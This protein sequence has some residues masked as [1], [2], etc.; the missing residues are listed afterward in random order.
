MRE[1]G[2]AIRVV[3]ADGFSATYPMTAEELRCHSRLQG[4]A[5]ND[6]LRQL[7]VL[8]ITHED[9]N[10]QTNLTKELT[11]KS[12]GSVTLPPTV[13]LQSGTSQSLHLASKHRPRSPHTP[14]RLI[15]PLRQPRM[16]SRRATPLRPHRQPTIRFPTHDIVQLI[17]VVRT[18]D[19]SNLPHSN[20]EFVHI[21]FCP[22]ENYR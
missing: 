3:S 14:Q 1:G 15:S 22:H 19:K 21:S 10:Q 18:T 2:R 13:R 11:A 7:A 8:R 12:T 5:A 20:S 6:Y 16:G 17:S 4:E 9:A